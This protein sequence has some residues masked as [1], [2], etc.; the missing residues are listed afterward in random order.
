MLK[1]GIVRK[2]R[3]SC[4]VALALLFVVVPVWLIA[5]TILNGSGGSFP[6]PVYAMWVKAYQQVH[7]DAKIEYQ[8]IG[9]G[10]GIRFIMEGKVDFGGSDAPMTDKQMQDYKSKHGYDILHFPT[11]IGAAVPVYNIPGSPELNFTPER[12]S[13]IYLGTITKWNDPAIREA[14]PKAN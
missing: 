2:A 11:V 8:P 12:L 3:K 4:G 6:A 14:N 7:P 13:G 9:S 10:G 1:R 5:E